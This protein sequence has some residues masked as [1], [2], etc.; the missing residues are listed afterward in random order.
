MVVYTLL[1]PYPTLNFYAM[2]IGC[3][4]YLVYLCIQKN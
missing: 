4:T 2:V 1:Y 3:V